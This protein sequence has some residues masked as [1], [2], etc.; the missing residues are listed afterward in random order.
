MDP[1][2][3]MEMVGTC[4]R[5][6]NDTQ[7]D[8]EQRLACIR[9]CGEWYP[10]EHLA[11]AWPS[12][13]AVGSRAQPQPWPWAPAPCPVC[14]ADMHIGYREELRYDYCGLHGVWLDAGEIVR[15]AQLFDLT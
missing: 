12:V 3:G 8:G 14:R 6:G 9:G 1:Y 11:K 5:C 10:R 7:S 4:P 13:T 15:F 2:R